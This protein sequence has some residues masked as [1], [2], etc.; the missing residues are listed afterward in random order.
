[1]LQR[2]KLLVEAPRV[3][4]CTCNFRLVARY[5]AALPGELYLWRTQ[6]LVR[7]PVILPGSLLRFIT[8][9]VK[10]GD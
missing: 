6:G 7:L 10:I 1:M 5:G 4:P 8:S 9:Q 2:V 3:G